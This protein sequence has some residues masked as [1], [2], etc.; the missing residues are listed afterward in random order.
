MT[1]WKGRP[2]FK[3]YM[4]NNPDRYGIKV[5]LGYESQ[6][7]YICN[8]E[9]CTRKPRPVKKNLV[10]ELLGAQ[11]LHK[12][13]HLYQDNYYNSVELSEMLL[14]KDTKVCGTLRLERG[15]PKEKKDKNKI[16]EE[17]KGPLTA[18]KAKLWYKYSE[19]RRCK[20]Y[21]NPTHSKDCGDRQEKQEG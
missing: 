14:E 1:A 16:P 15:V 12:G 8:L 10:L 13:Y 18:I 4:L 2:T 6:R 11:M 19:I 20:A 17:K 5:Y 21:L 7:G 3:V 9:V